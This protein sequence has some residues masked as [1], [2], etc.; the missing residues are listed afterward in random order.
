MMFSSELEINPHMIIVVLMFLGSV[1]SLYNCVTNGVTRSCTR[2]ILSKIFSFFV[3]VTARS[4][5]ELILFGMVKRN[6]IEEG[7]TQNMERIN[8]GPNGLSQK[9][10][11]KRELKERTEA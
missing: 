11:L 2:T 5:L 6:I 10:K 1:G 9:R 8:R 7:V 4:L 3:F